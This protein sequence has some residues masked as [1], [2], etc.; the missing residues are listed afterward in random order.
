MESEQ[1]KLEKHFDDM[2][3]KMKADK[4]YEMVT[5]DGTIEQG[6]D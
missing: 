6:F 4:E 5:I 3:K 1:E 2:E